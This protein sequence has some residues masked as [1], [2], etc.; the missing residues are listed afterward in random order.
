GNQPQIQEPGVQPPGI[1]YLCFEGITNIQAKSLFH[2]SNYPGLASVDM[3]FDFVGP[4]ASVSYAVQ[5]ANAPAPP[6]PGSYVPLALQNSGH[7][8]AYKFLNVG[9]QYRL[10]AK[11]VDTNG[12]T[13]S[14]ELLFTV[15]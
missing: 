3:S 10:Y 9:W 12:Q 5:P 15:S 13:F 2:A 14:K 6:T 11:V 1:C 4:A 8:D 7:Y